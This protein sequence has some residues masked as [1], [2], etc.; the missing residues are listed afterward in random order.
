M[1]PERHFFLTLGRI[2]WLVQGAQTHTAVLHN[3][4]VFPHISWGADGHCIG[5]QALMGIVFSLGLK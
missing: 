3:T 2:G 1:N 4:A 5:I